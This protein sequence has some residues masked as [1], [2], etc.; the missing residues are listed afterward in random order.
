MGIPEFD[1]L[2]I[3]SMTQDH[4]G[5]LWFSTNGGLASYD[6]YKAKVYGM[7]NENTPVLFSVIKDSENTIY[8]IT[9][10]GEIF[11]IK[12][13]SLQRYY[14]LPEKLRSRGFLIQITKDDEILIVSKQICVLNKQKD[15]RVLTDSSFSN[16]LETT[17]YDNDLYF[18]DALID[19]KKRGLAERRIGHLDSNLNLSYN[20]SPDYI[21]KFKFPRKIFK[22]NSGVLYQTREENVFLGKNSNGR[23]ERQI[24]KLENEERIIKHESRFI[25]INN[26]LW[27]FDRNPGA[28]VYDKKGKLAYGETKIFQD[29]FVNCFLK[30][31]DQNTWIGT[32]G[33][34]LYCIPYN[35]SITFG[36]QPDLNGKHVKVICTVSA[37]ETYVGTAEG[38]VYHLNNNK[39]TLVYKH[40]ASIDLIRYRPDR[41]L[42]VINTLILDLRTKKI[43]S[44]LGDRISAYS[45]QA[46]SPYEDI[47]ST[48]SNLYIIDY[49]RELVEYKQLDADADDNGKAAH[50]LEYDK[51]YNYL[52]LLTN[53]GVFRKHLDSTAISPVY[54]KGKIL[55]QIPTYLNGLMY[56]KTFGKLYLTDNLQITDS[57]TKE[58]G[59]NDFHIYSR[60]HENRLYMVAGRSFQCFNPVTKERLL[61]ISTGPL[62][63]KLVDFQI[64]DS[65]V[66]FIDRFDL[67][68]TSISTLSRNT[69]IVD[70][71]IDAI[72]INGKKQYNG[73]TSFLPTENNITFK[74][75]T[76]SHL[77]EGN[78]VY[79]YRLKGLNDDW[80]TV[81]FNQNTINYHGLPSGDY[82]FEIKAYNGDN[83]ASELTSYSFTIGTPWY[84]TW[85]FRMI[86]AAVTFIA[87][88]LLYRNL[89]RTLA[90]ERDINMAKI[91]AIKAQMNPHFVFNALNSVQDLIIQ[92]DIRN[93]NIYLGKFA[94]LMRQTLDYSQLEQ[95]SVRKELDTAILYLDLEKLRFGDDFTFTLNTSLSEDELNELNIPSL[96]LQPYL[97]NAIKHGLLHTKGKKDLQIN[98]EKSTEAFTIDIVDN[99]VGRDKAAEI[100]ARR[101]KGHNSFALSANKR[102]LELIKQST[103]NEIAY[104]ISDVEPTGTKVSFTFKL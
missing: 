59:L 38:E 80:L 84:S 32:A 50:F 64:Q 104:A 69:E 49:K 91:N 26:Q 88:R 95:I 77:H 31:K 4:N 7:Y 86:I 81:D 16:V 101:N 34:G 27:L 13:D 28:Y 57:I 36:N 103:G 11:C 73:S 17:L 76:S 22:Y 48:N 67:Q 19:K 89:K 33:K 82:T 46:I 100:N 72:L 43:H 5:K 10:T 56:V 92:K 58:D 98:L 94:D 62:A 23:I 24:L 21:E 90:L 78:I 47:V 6:G 79:E 52:Y 85:W 97:E 3:Y 12:N 71:V 65:T 63:N 41:N 102:R 25:E 70:V 35:K 55:H 51:K 45:W 61:N 18:I 96:L 68:K 44:K 99:G 29:K 42:L 9:L 75:Y 54:F 39:L 60:A 37:N 2:S 93:S 20:T 14:T 40:T 66:W 83:I 30:D 74:Y 87:L 53:A 15:L 1:E 8:A